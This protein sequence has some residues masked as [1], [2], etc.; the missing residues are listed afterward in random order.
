MPY[1]NRQVTAG[2]RNE[3]REAV[4]KGGSCKTGTLLNCDWVLSPRLIFSA[5]ICYNRLYGRLSRI[6]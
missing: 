6:P 2:A 1:N 5:G 3:R 4:K